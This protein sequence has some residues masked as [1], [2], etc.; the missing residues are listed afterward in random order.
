MDQT[1][2]LVA[3]ASGALAFT[4]QTWTDFWASSGYDARVALKAAGYKVFQE[5]G[6]WESH[7][8]YLRASKGDGSTIVFAVGS[9]D[10]TNDDF[11]LYRC[12]S[13]DV[14]GMLAAQLGVPLST[15]AR[16]IN[17]GQTVMDL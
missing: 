7:A 12:D 10:A 16:A 14:A 4:E 9:K 17:S 13:A 8:G 5:L 1:F 3:Y 6:D 11:V 2:F 15:D